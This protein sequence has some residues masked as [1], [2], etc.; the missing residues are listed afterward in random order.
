MVFL[1]K[2]KGAKED[3][4]T[5]EAKQHLTFMNLESN[6][7]DVISVASKEIRRKLSLS[8][9][10]MG[11]SDVITYT[12]DFDTLILR[13]LNTYANRYLLVSL[14]LHCSY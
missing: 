5:E 12:S 10:L 13:L 1:S 3:D 4:A 9:A 8:I 7:D 11:M 6:A 14:I 2:L